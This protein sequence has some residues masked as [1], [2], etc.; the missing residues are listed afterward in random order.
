MRRNG[1]ENQAAIVLAGYEYNKPPSSD[2]RGYGNVW[3]NSGAEVILS[4]NGLILK[5]SRLKAANT[6]QVNLG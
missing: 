5:R 4:G 1:Q 6:T 3:T 2:G